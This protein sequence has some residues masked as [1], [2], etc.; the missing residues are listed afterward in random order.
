MLLQCCRIFIFASLLQPHWPMKYSA[1]FIL[2]AMLLA[3]SSAALEFIAHR[4]N[5]N[6]PIENSLE[7]TRRALKSPVGAIELDV[8]VSSDGFVY[9]YHNDV[10]DGKKLN[11]LSFEEIRALAGESKTPTLKQIFSLEE[12]RDFYLLDLK[13]NKME[14]LDPLVSLVRASD[15]EMRKIVFQSHRLEILQRLE[16]KVPG[17][18]RVYLNSLTRAPPYFIIPSAKMLLS[19]ISDYAIDGISLQGR[20]FLDT[21]YISTLKEQGLSVY[22]W[23]VND[24]ERIRYYASIG[25]DRVITDRYREIEKSLAENPRSFSPSEMELSPRRASSLLELWRQKTQ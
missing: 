8:R 5:Y 7:A 16:N 24:F 14:A 25:V 11:E 21:K 2:V 6:Y 9:L 20:H 23:T 10:I 4:A 12:P 17:S 22:V 15:I 18:K 1:L 3:E 13:I 19:A